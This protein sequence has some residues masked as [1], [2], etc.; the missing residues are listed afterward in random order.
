MLMDANGA[1]Q[2]AL[3]HSTQGFSPTWS[4]D[5]S[6]LAFVRGDFD[7]VGNDGKG[8]LYVIDMTQG[9]EGDHETLI[10]GTLQVSRPS[11]GS[12]N[13]IV[14]ACLQPRPGGGNDVL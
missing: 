10:P 5:G 14:Y 13:R 8:A 4:P 6:R 3:A 7:S 1:N 2:R 11:W 12:N 9:N